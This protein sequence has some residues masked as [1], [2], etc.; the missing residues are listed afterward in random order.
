[1]GRYPAELESAVY[2]CVLEALQNALK[3]A[4][5]VR[6]IT[7]DLDGATAAELRFAVRD[8]GAG[9]RR[10]DALRAGAGLT[11]MRDRVAA[12]GGHLDIASAVGVGTT[13][14]GLVRTDVEAAP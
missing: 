13:V 3:H 8:D 1:V 11:G 5:G 10:G 9:V 4:N 12:F 2:F 6:R 7:V 14:R